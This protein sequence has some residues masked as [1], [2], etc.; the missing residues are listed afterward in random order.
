MLSPVAI[1]GV[2]DLKEEIGA[3]NL[4]QRGAE[5]VNELMWQLVNEAHRI[6]DDRMC[7]A[8]KA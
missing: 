1:R 5:G 4:F 3:C 6:G 8:R 7:A 2:D